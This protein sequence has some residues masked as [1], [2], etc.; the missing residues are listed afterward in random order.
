MVKEV[1][2]VGT[3]WT[4]AQRSPWGTVYGGPLQKE[5]NPLDVSH[6]LLV[7]VLLG[8]EV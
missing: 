8:I 2:M 1:F 5:S 4:G 3:H 6:N 7:T